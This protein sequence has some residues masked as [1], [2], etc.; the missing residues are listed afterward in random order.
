[1]LESS[2]LIRSREGVAERSEVKGESIKKRRTINQTNGQANQKTKAVF[3]Q[4]RKRALRE[5]ALIKQGKLK[6]KSLKN[7]LREL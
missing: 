6:P 4:R 1:M 5:V 7:L 2:P 3:F